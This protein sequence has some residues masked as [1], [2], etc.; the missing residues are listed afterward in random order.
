MSGATW[1]RGNLT[2]AAFAVLAAVWLL[3]ASRVL[4]TPVPR[5]AGGALWCR[6]GCM[7]WISSVTGIRAIRFRLGRTPRTRQASP[8]TPPASGACR[9]RA[10]PVRTERH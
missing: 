4:R 2:L 10:S 1:R 7:G 5:V 9:R 8:R 6:V 3:A